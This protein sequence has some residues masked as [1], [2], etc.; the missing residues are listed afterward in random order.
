MSGSV[1]RA[2]EILG[3]AGFSPLPQPV[4]VGEVPFQFSVVLVSKES[5][6]LVVLVDTFEDGSEE[7]VRGEVM[8]LARALDLAGSRRPLTVV[9]IGQRWSEIT[10]RAISRVARVLRCQVVLGDDARDAALRDALAVLLPLNLPK[11][12]EEPEE[13]WSAIRMQ[14]EQDLDDSDLREVLL[15]ASRG[16]GSVKQAL[17]NYLAAP[18]EVETNE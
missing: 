15:V 10:E 14:L 3:A 1:D 13:T 5:L 4:Q 12:P 6:D 9:L 8:A 18:L 2:V 11:V 7:V 16:Q 17:R